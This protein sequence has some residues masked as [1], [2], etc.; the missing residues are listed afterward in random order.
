MF[1]SGLFH[2]FVFELN[3]FILCSFFL[4]IKY[5]LVFIFKNSFSTFALCCYPSL[6]IK[7]LIPANNWSC[8]AF[9][10]AS[11]WH[12][13]LQPSH[14]EW[15]MPQAPMEWICCAFQSFS[16]KTWSSYAAEV[17]EVLS[18]PWWPLM[19]SWFSVFPLCLFVPTQV[20]SQV[21]NLMN[22]QK[23]CAVNNDYKGY[24]REEIFCWVVQWYIW[25]TK[26]ETLL[27]ELS[28]VRKGGIHNTAACQTALCLQEQWAVPQSLCS[29]QKCKRLRSPG[30]ENSAGT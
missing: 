26:D 5:F 11:L 12:T 20:L 1:L 4:L 8:A 24:W 10:N 25:V 9:L 28:K 23:N 2:Q 6:S 7:M 22:N 18:S 13:L 14:Y 16:E 3:T 17:L 21:I 29:P 15:R 30:P 19:T 27:Q